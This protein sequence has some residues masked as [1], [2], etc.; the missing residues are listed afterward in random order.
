MNDTIK[1][2]LK[3]LPNN[4]GTYQMLDKAGKIIYVGKAKN[5]KNR[6]SS[7]FVGVHD[8]K[9]TRLVKDIEDFRYII[10]NSEKEA[11]L[12]ELNQIKNHIPKYNI[13]L[14]GSNTYPY[15]EITNE[16]YPRLRI[17]RNIKRNNSNE[18]K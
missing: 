2:K 11:L 7:Y 18:Y 13:Q 6:V 5:L 10:T 8:L 3:K 12:L 17:T 1:N 15:I 4:P 16:T 9:T 14:V